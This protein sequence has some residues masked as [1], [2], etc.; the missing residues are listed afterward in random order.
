M[1]D[2]ALA[3]QTVFRMVL[4][5]RVILA[6]SLLAIIAS[7]PLLIIL[8]WFGIIVTGS[9]VVFF[10]SHIK[11]LN[12]L[13]ARYK[14][15]RKWY[16]SYMVSG[17]LSGAASTLGFYILWELSHGVDTEE[18]PFILYLFMTVIGAP[19]ITFFVLFAAY[20]WNRQFSAG[21]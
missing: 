19:V 8:S 18:T 13:H 7:L 17:F 4:F 11:Y 5:A 1:P 9:L 6:L 2:A 14:L 12:A 16:T 15:T 10:V 3:E 20:R 21:S